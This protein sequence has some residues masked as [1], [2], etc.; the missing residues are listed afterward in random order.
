MKNREQIENLMCPVCKDKKIEIHISNGVAFR[1]QCE[2]HIWTCHMKT[3]YYTKSENAIKAGKRLA[4][5]IYRCLSQ[6]EV[7]GAM[8]DEPI[9][10]PDIKSLCISCEFEPHECEAHG[11]D[12]E[13][14]E[15]WDIITKC[16]FHKKENPSC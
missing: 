11:E 7:F 9:N 16:K 4:K 13:C 2:N 15:D 1:A 14:F 3:E 12:I 10:Y 5:G 8:L 6:E